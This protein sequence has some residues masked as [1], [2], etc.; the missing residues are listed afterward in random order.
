MTSSRPRILFCSPHP[1]HGRSY[2]GQLRTLNIARLL[3]QSGDVRVA[4]FPLTDPEPESIDRT[5]AEFD[6]REIIPLR[7]RPTRGWRHR[8]AHEFDPF[9]PNTH[10]YNLDPAAVERFDRLVDQH[11]VV[12]F[13]GIRVPNAL[14][15]RVWRRSVL[16]IDD[17][18]SLYFRSATQQAPTTRLK[19]RALRK[20]W[21]WGRRERVLSRRFT[22][23]CVCS[24]QDRAFFGGGSHVH[25]IPNG[26]EIPSPTPAHAPVDPPRIGFIGKLEYAPNADGVTW[27]IDQVWPKIR[28][29]RPDAR[30]R[31]AGVGGEH[32]AARHAEGIDRLGWIADPATE[33]ASWSSMIV[34]IHVGGGTRIKIAEA[35]SRKCPV[36]STRL[37][38][39]GYPIDDRKELL[40]A[41]SPDAFATACLELIDNRE[42]ATR[43]S[44]QA[45]HR[46]L[47]EWSWPAIGS[48]VTSA[49]EHCLQNSAQSR[50]SKT[51]SKTES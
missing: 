22:T 51:W 14:G 35:F 45:W 3:Q 49:V 4:L 8:F 30:F 41:D 44:T 34:P 31:I 47:D 9:Y 12:W 21:L 36:V 10:G 25:H 37:G 18:P 29:V 11:D 13:H 20:H 23:L 48:R 40:L 28:A 39:F 32:L 27:F 26:F 16:D 43:L 19:L 5:R 7:S 6:L 15:R 33:V 17:V 42:L 2:G 46:F 1:L 50:E 24:E 38:A